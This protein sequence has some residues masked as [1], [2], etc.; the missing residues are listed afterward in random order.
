MRLTSF[1]C[2]KLEEYGDV[3]KSEKTF[4]CF[5]CGKRIKK[6]S[7]FFNYYDPGWWNDPEVFE[8]WCLECASKVYLGKILIN[9]LK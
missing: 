2:R 3:E 4:N 6:G 1:L 7:L 8:D 5:S 9:Y